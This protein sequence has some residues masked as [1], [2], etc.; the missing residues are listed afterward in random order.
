MQ[1]KMRKIVL[2]HFCW[3]TCSWL[4]VAHFAAF[5][6]SQ[7]QT[8]ATFVQRC[9]HPWH[10]LSKLWNLVHPDAC[11]T[12]QRATICH[13]QSELD[14]L[15]QALAANQPCRSQNEP[16][17]AVADHMHTLGFHW[18]RATK[19]RLCACTA[20]ADG[21][22]KLGHQLTGKWT[23]LVDRIASLGSRSCEG[24][25]Q[26]CCGDG[27]VHHGSFCVPSAAGD[28]QNKAHP[29]SPEAQKWHCCALTKAGGNHNCPA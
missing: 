14:S 9:P 15:Q 20:L 24:S 3:P 5:C 23:E 29:V 11:N 1:E 6:S 7:L 27:S 22:R 13:W 8:D 25:S 28:R 12:S 4:T 17:F 19:N 16:S 26:I 10:T 2:S 21:A 18:N